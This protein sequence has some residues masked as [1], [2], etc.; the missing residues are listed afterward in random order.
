MPPSSRFGAGSA[1]RA[2][3]R[4]VRRGDGKAEVGVASAC[5]TALNRFV[6]WQAGNTAALL[7]PDWYMLN[8]TG[9]FIGAVLAQFATG[10]FISLL[11]L[12]V[13]RAEAI[14]NLTSFRMPDAGGPAPCRMRV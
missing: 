6:A 1:R 3:S 12:F 10:L 4:L 13:G 7:V 11:M 5:L 14:E 9:P 2:A 8:G